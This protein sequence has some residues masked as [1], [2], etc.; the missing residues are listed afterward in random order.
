M[1]PSKGPGRRQTGDLNLSW[2]GI[3]NT[4]IH[5]EAELCEDAERMGLDFGL[6]GVLE[7]FRDQFSDGWRI[8][9]PR[10]VKSWNGFG[11]F[12]WG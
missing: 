5:R 6:Q 7:H 1:S 11:I 2:K 8:S 10:A 12:M 4:P 9:R 3:K